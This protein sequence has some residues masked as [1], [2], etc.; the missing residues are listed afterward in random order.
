MEPAYY[1]PSQ[2]KNLLKALGKNPRKALSQN[3]LIDGNILKKIILAADVQPNDWVLEIG[4]GPGALSY[5]LVRSGAKLVAVEKDPAFAGHLK[6]SKLPG[7]AV[8]TEDFLQTDL[9][10][11]PLLF[12]GL[13]SPLKSKTPDQIKV[14]A[15]LPYHIT[16]PILL[17]LFESSPL[18]TSFT[19]MV[20][21]EFARRLIA[22]PRTKDYSSLTL[23]AQTYAEISLSFLVSAASFYPQPKVASAVLFFRL[24][25]PPLKQPDLKSWHAFVQKAF[26][27]RRKKLTS[28]LA[29]NFAKEK[30]ASALVALK[31]NPDSRPEELAFNA[32]LAL[33]QKL[34]TEKSP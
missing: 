17:K 23:L 13:C 29:K 14:I 12:T 21:K 34:Q 3:F 20:Q 16:T 31:L 27:Q 9:E 26:Q 32:F 28:S 30:I 10:K 15:N 5:A 1:Q 2:L 8:L 24:K 25:P 33:F 22:R 7:L 6:N 18:F 19:L 11:L 4:S